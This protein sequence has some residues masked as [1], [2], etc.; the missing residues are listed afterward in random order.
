MQERLFA[1]VSV[2]KKQ[3]DS[4]PRRFELATGF[5]VASR[6][7]LTSGHVLHDKDRDDAAPIEVCFPERDRERSFTA[8]IVWD[9]TDVDLD[10]AVLELDSPVEE[11]EALARV[12]LGFSPLAGLRTWEARG[13]PSA[14]AQSQGDGSHARRLEPFSGTAYS[15]TA[16]AHECVLDVEVKPEHAADWGGMSGAPVFCEDRLIA[17]VRSYPGSFEGSR[18]RGVPIAAM[19]CE[20]GFRKALGLAEGDSFASVKAALHKEI[21][22]VW[23]SARAPLMAALASYGLSE[24]ESTPRAAT[25]ALASALTVAEVLDVLDRVHGELM[26]RD[27]RAAT[28]IERVLWSLLPFLYGTSEDQPSV[29]RGGRSVSVL[30]VPVA[31]PTLAELISADLD[32]APVCF[33]CP[34]RLSDPPNGTF[35]VG[36]TPELGVMSGPEEVVREIRSQLE[37][38]LL[39]ERERR[40]SSRAITE[41]LNLR[42]GFR[43]TRADRRRRYYVVLERES[44]EGW[45]DRLIVELKL[46]LP[47]LRVLILDGD[48]DAWV[49]ESDLAQPMTQILHRSRE[50]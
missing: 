27:R 40:R 10:A 16:G 34:P 44:Y 32:G 26:S 2:P 1:Q 37:R 14:G 36:D 12:W 46:T 5:L 21:S 20:P 24:L 39:T 9:G 43:A 42:I 33:E 17:V 19:R 6:S 31:T 49:R 47:E 29:P 30:S 7:V 25:E 45:L 3:V 41:V 18:L 11:S 22:S 50:P 13:Y 15:W 35:L 23:E 8:R 48:E 4:G 38:E 28:G